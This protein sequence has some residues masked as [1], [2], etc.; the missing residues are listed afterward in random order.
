MPRYFFHTRIGNDLIS[1]RKGALVR[2][3][4]HAWEVGL[5]LIQDLLKERPRQLWLL[6][7]YLEVAADNGQVVLEFPFRSARAVV[8]T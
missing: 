8:C 6:T 7:V 4:D 1:D 3:A 2:D 5:V